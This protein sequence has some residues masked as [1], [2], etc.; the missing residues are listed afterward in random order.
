MLTRE[1]P[2]KDTP[3][4]APQRCSKADEVLC[5]CALR[6]GKFPP[7]VSADNKVNPSLTDYHCVRPMFDASPFVYDSEAGCHVQSALS[8]TKS[9]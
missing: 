5:S 4:N 3:S 8:K 6:A 7:G 2:G 1:R 9:R